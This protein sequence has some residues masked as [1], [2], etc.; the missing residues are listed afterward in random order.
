MFWVR[1][2]NT[3][4][5]ARTF[6]HSKYV[7][8]S[9]RDN[10]TNTDPPHVAHRHTAAAHAK[11][12]RLQAND[13]IAD[14]ADADD[15]DDDADDTPQHATKPTSTAKRKSRYVRKR[16]EERKK[17]GPKPQ[18]RVT[19]TCYE[20]HKTFK[21]PAQLQLHIRTHT[22]DRPFGCSFCSRRFA[23]KHNLAI[24][25]RTHTGERPF[26]C[27]ICSKQFAALGNFQ[28]HKKIHSG[29][30]DQLCPVCQ[31]AFVTAG[32]LARHMTTHTGIKNHHCDVCG[33]AFS[34]NRDMLVH[35][36][37]LHAGGLPPAG[38]MQQQQQ[39]AQTD[40]AET[41]RC[42]ECHKVFETALGLATHARTSHHDP[43]LSGDTTVLPIQPTAIN[44][45]TVPVAGLNGGLIGG[46]TQ[47]HVMS[48]VPPHHHQHPHM[49]PPLPPPPTM[50]GHQSSGMMHHHVHHAQHHHHHAAAAAVVAHHH[51]PSHHHHHPQR[52][53]PF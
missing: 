37:K 2:S 13:D 30:R 4:N 38:M 28:A 29:V 20:C 33:R 40:A 18:P 7:N 43:S 1:I 19:P 31:K 49:G 25:V 34:R 9:T 47:P 24:H 23:Q 3:H 48:V 26:Q 21:C 5:G 53:H 51:H 39:P 41:Y 22:G 16:P 36:R 6:K 17:R 42:R 12:Q 45:S 10:E 44:G 8:H 15:D 50:M 52:L 46:L 14:D 27:E 35:K 32:D 11:H